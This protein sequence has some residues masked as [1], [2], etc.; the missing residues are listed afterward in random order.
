MMLISWCWAAA[1]D[2]EQ[3]L[4]LSWCCWAAAAVDADDDA[5][6]LLLM[7]SCCCYCCYC[8]CC[9]YCWCWCWFCC[10]SGSDTCCARPSW[11][12]NSDATSYHW[13]RCSWSCPSL[14][15]SL[16]RSC[17]SMSCHVSCCIFSR[18]LSVNFYDGTAAVTAPWTLHYHHISAIIVAGL[19]PSLSVSLQSASL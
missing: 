14:R 19:H 5:E 7:L 10:L 8:C 11:R 6:Q 15:R 4:M 9:C 3:L 2:A 12:R 18:L 13:A 1:A 16:P 17:E